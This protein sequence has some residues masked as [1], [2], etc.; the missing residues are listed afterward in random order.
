MAWV[1]VAVAGA[2]LVGGAISANAASNAADQQAQSAQDAQNIQQGMY[3]DTV[4]REQPFVQSGQE[5]QGQ[6]NYLLGI[7][8]PGQNG[9]VSSS[10]YGGFGS[11]NAP[12]TADTFKQYAPAYQFQLQQGGQGVLNGDASAVGAG[13][14]A[15]LKD[16]TSFNQNFANTSFNNAF[17]QYQTQ[18]GNIFSRLAGIAQQG[19]AAASNSATGGSNYSASIGQSATNVGTALAGGTIGSANAITGALNSA[20]PWLVYNQPKTQTPGTTN[21]NWTDQ[22]VATQVS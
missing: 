22:A 5:A 4:S 14:G 2:S 21:N 6:L 13:S 15:A 16:L 19:Q 10:Q 20:A 12:F 3:N 8:T 1:A 17:N 9:E 11:L 7:G 18:Q